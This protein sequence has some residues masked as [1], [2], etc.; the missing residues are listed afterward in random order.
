MRAAVVAAAALSFCSRL[1]R[2]CPACD[3]PGAPAP[4]FDTV[5]ALL[6]AGSLFLVIREL[7]R[8]LLRR[9]ARPRADALPSTE[10]NNPP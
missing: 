9:L 2:A 1:A 5:T 10:S 3:H 4:G 7:V 8:R 6:V